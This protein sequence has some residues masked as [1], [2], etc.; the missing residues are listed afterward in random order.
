MKTTEHRSD[1]VVI[2]GGLA[3]LAAAA[4]IA[5][6]GNTVKL[7]EQSHALGGR[8][9]TKQRDGFSLNIGPHALYRGGPGIKVLRELGIEPRGGIPS[10]SGG[11]AI[12][13]GV[14]H[15]FPAGALSLLTTN[16]F[17]LSAKLEA[18]RLLASIARISVLR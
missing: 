17:G 12:K 13:D 2:G 1:V 18:G 4:L 14:K 10:V 11:F 6:Q 16:L 3:G 8:A 7:V 15:T 9:Q 5:K